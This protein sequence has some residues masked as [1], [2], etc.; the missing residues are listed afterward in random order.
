MA[1]PVTPYTA[2]VPSGSISNVQV[3]SI[4]L[5]VE[6]IDYDA[7]YDTDDITHTLAGGFQVLIPTICRITCTCGGG[8]DLNVHY[9]AVPPNI[10]PGQ[11]LTFIFTPDGVKLYNVTALVTKFAWK[12]GPK[13][14]VRWNGEFRGTG[15]QTNAYPTN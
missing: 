7:T 10:V 9:H 13:T 12:G 5:A 1:T 14:A 11:T 3:G 8:Y 6:D 4:N 15:F 2:N